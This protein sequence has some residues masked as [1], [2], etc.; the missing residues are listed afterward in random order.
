MGYHT[1][2]WG[3]GDT[4]CKWGWGLSWWGW[5]RKS[6]FGHCESSMSGAAK[7]WLVLASGQSL[8]KLR[9]CGD[10]SAANTR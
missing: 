2:N 10:F 8:T 7:K 5:G 3:Y 4:T 1:E 6:I 9:T